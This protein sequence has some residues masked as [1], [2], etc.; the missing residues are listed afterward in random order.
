VHRRWLDVFGVEIL[1]G[2]GS[3]EA[4]HI[5]ISNR[6][7]RARPGSVGQVCPGYE[8]IVVG[9]DGSE[10]PD[11]EPGELNVKGESTA[12]CYWADHEKSKRTFSGDWILSGDLFVRDADG[13]FWYQG[14]A[15][16]LLKVSGIWVAPL[17]IE[18]CLLAHPRV[19]ECAVVGHE[20]DGLT[21]PRAF[22]VAASEGDDLQA[23]GLELVEHVRGE[24]APHK[25]PRDV[26]FLDALPKT[27]NGKVDRKALTEGQR[28]P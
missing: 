18:N 17:E 14:R 10:V 4:Y 2:I 25:A 22:V 11:G 21:V 1:D 20:Q 12:M 9:E 24:L 16:D 8:A 26:R 28:A 23:L 15:D 13:Y 3:S 7:G 6:P 5:Y 27:A 19:R